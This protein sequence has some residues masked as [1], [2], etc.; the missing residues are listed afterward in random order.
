MAAGRPSSYKPEYAAQAEKLCKLGATDIEVA[1][2][3]ALLPTEE[4]WLYACL[5]VIRQDR[6]GVI[7]AQKRG[8][9]AQ[10][11]TWLGRS[12]SQ[13]VRN[14]VSARMWAA[15]KGRSD[16]ALFSRLGYSVA[17]LMEHLERQFTPDMSWDNY[18]DWH[19]DHIAPCASF[20][21]TDDRQFAECWAMSNLRPLS[22]MDNIRKGAK[23]VTP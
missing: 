23:N 6:R 22:A 14:A 15:L 12:P 18:G 7:A 17:D 20:D 8:R 2:F 16:G 11:K 4:D 1:D 13:R 5:M 10:R 21:M 9:S 3:F 19:V